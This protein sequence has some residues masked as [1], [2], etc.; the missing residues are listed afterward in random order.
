MR[1]TQRAQ[2]EQWWALGGLTDLHFMQYRHCTRPHTF[3]EKESMTFSS[4][5]C[6]SLLVKLYTRFSIGDKL[7]TSTLSV[8]IASTE[9]SSYLG[10]ISFCFSL[11]SVIFVSVIIAF[12]ISYVASSTSAG[13][14]TA[15]YYCSMS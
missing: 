10:S 12:I 4:I 2:L 13:D 8:I 3:K 9:A 7:L 5:S 1:R 6:H 11:V 15:I 14:S